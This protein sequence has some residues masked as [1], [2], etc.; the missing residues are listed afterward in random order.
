MPDYSRRPGAPKESPR[1]TIERLTRELEA[2]RRDRPKPV[3][4]LPLVKL[5]PEESTSWPPGTAWLDTSVVLA[6]GDL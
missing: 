5:D 2:A 4:K 3:S 6:E 1:Q